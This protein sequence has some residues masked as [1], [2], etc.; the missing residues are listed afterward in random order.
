MQVEG[1]IKC[2]Q[3]IFGGRGI[4]GFEDFTPFQTWA[5]FPFGPWTWGSKNRIGSKNSCK[6]SLR[7]KPILMG[8]AISISEILLLFV[9]L[10]KQ[11]KFPFK[12]WTIIAH[13]SQKIESAQ[14]IYASRG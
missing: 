1:D 11:P 10:Q 8:M 5:N 3:A 4:F 7:Q 14:K 9:C 13:G 2:M 6:Q 12:P